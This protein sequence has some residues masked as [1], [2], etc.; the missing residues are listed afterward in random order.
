MCVIG[1][2]GLVAITSVSGVGQ[3][4]AASSSS[5]ACELLRLS[6]PDR[7]CVFAAADTGEP[8]HSSSPRA[9]LPNLDE[10]LAAPLPN[11][12]KEASPKE[13]Q[14]ITHRAIYAALGVELDEPKSLSSFAWGQEVKVAAAGATPLAWGLPRGSDTYGVESLDG[15]PAGHDLT[16]QHTTVAGGATLAL[17]P[18][19][20]QASSTTARI[21]PG[22]PVVPSLA[23]QEPL[24]LGRGTPANQNRALR[25]GSTSSSGW[26]LGAGSAAAAALSMVWNEFGRP[27]VKKVTAYLALGPVAGTAYAALDF[28]SGSSVGNGELVE[29]R[30]VAPHPPTTDS[31]GAYEIVRVQGDGAVIRHRQSGHTF[32]TEDPDLLAAAGRDTRTNVVSMVDNR[33]DWFS[34]L[35]VPL[36]P[37]TSL[38]Q[39]DREAIEALYHQLA[40][41]TGSNLDWRNKAT[42]G[43]K[44][45]NKLLNPIG[46]SLVYPRL[47]E[48]ADP[49]GDFDSDGADPRTFWIKA[50]GG[51][52]QGMNNWHDFLAGLPNERLPVSS[53]D[54]VSK[55]VAA[56][57]GN[58]WGLLQRIYPS[59]RPQVTVTRRDSTQSL[60]TRSLDILAQL[61]DSLSDR[62]TPLTRSIVQA[63]SPT[64]DK[65]D[66]TQNAIH[67]A[68]DQLSGATARPSDAAVVLYDSEEEELTRWG[69]AGDSIVAELNDGDHTIRVQIPRV[70]GEDPM[71]TLRRLRREV[72]R[73]AARLLD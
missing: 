41:S 47:E 53:F 14:G 63:A 3:E 45:V 1:C 16:P 46:L 23:L 52:N 8:H 58:P 49:N 48:D 51:R 21:V 31:M 60:S 70:N 7:E 15:P 42:R 6:D 34:S 35:Q 61:R 64:L 55:F 25:S 57:G 4:I 73:L 71:E 17:S 11:G 2:I 59:G 20:L 5:V 54:E 12:P 27:I 32:F 18:P 26:S 24:R 30:E 33:R 29:S 69:T 66:D 10:V 9:H 50:D 72:E 13:H 36:A 44:E 19:S 56:L 68:L 37:V 39:G 43:L 38:T 22:Q 67:K 40:A 65:S 28:L 62:E